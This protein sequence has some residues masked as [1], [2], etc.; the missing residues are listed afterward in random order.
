VQ[1]LQIQDQG[2]VVHII[3]IIITTTTTTT[4]T[5]P[6]LCIYLFVYFNFKS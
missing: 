5:T 3:I 4:T 2:G 1:V 6:Y